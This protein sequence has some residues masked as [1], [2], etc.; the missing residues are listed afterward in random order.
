MAINLTKGGRVNLEKEAPGLS[1]VGV[2]LGWDVNATD[3]GAA[4]DLDASVF[5]LDASGKAPGDKYFVYFNNL[6]SADGALEHTGDNL[7]GEGEGDDETIHVDLKKIDP[8]IT[9]IVFVVTI[10]DAEKRKQ[11]FGQVR[12]AFIR[13]YNKATG[14]NIAKYELDEDYSGET[15]V[16]FGRMYKKDD[17]WRFNAVGQ[18]FAGGLERF[19]AMF[20]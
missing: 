6:K 3:T 1:A 13:I 12:N 7:T 4:Y 5:M 8:K 17:Q 11:N 2:G 10:Y 18:G 15:A 9:E 16:E 20:L 19:T 14:E